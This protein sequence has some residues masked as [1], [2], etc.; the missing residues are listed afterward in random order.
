MSLGR[1]VNRLLSPLGLA[2]SRRADAPRRATAEAALQALSRLGGVEPQ[3]VIDVGAA[4]GDWSANASRHFPSARF[5]LVE[6]LTEFSELLERR[7][8]E[9]SDAVLVGAVAGDTTG[10]ATLHVHADLVGTSLHDE[11]GLS[12]EERVVEMT[13]VDQVVV[14]HD[15][16]GPFVMKLDVQGAEL[17]VLRGAISTL[18]QTQL[19]QLESSL[20]PFYEGS[21]DVVGVLTHMRSAGFVLYDIVDLSYRPLDGALAQVDLFFVPESSPLREHHEYATSTQR[22]SADESLR[23]LYERRAGEIE[24]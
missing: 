8:R 22:R 20:F 21:S 16:R 1:T 10:S 4:Y 7:A 6:P 18:A 2:L 12:S 14:D 3:T 15:A 13:T 9:L 24:Q 5:L 19:V 23:S 17:E 11:P